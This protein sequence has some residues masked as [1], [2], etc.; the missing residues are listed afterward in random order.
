MA[1]FDGLFREPDLLQYEMNLVGSTSW[2]RIE[3]GFL[4]LTNPP[5][6]H[7]DLFLKAKPL[8]CMT[9]NAPAV[10]TGGQTI[11]HLDPAPCAAQ[12][13]SDEAGVKA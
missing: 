9:G 12:E 5:L 1:R 11:N 4:C 7:R 13:A 10:Q 3:E 2:I 8:W 6:R